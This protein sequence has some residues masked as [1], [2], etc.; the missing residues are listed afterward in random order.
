M[1]RV[2]DDPP[3]DLG[4]RDPMGHGGV[5]MKRIK[6]LGIAWM[7]YKILRCKAAGDTNKLVIN[8]SGVPDQEDLP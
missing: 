2:S 3:G 6:A 7:I 1:A 5:S 4:L 8:L